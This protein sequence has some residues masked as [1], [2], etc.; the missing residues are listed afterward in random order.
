MMTTWSFFF[1]LGWGLG[2]IVV[3]GGANTS[4]AAST[5]TLV[6]SCSVT[7]RLPFC[8]RVVMSAWI[9]ATLPSLEYPLLLRSVKVTMILPDFNSRL[10][11]R[12]AEMFS[13]CTSISMMDCLRVLYL[14]PYAYVL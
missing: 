1:G 6:P 5:A 13:F 7:T 8:A 12:D 10:T 9:L 14:L 4:E 3:V 11:I 2:G